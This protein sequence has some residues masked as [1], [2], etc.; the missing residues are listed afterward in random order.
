MSAGAVAA[1]E[2]NICSRSDGL[3]KVKKDIRV[4]IDA[5]FKE[6][7]ELELTLKSPQKAMNHIKAV[8]N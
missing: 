4:G 3:V 8:V 7:F 6:K 2:A 5:E 1:G